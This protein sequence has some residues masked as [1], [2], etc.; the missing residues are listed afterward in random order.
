MSR[1][2]V[3]KKLVYMYRSYTDFALLIVL[4][5]PT[6][7]ER[8]N[9]ERVSKMFN[10]VI[11][12]NSPN[13][14]SENSMIGK[15]SYLA[16]G[17]NE[18]IAKAQNIGIE[19]L[20]RTSAFKYI[21][22]FDQDS[23]FPN[24]YPSSIVGEYKRINTMLGG[25]L[26]CL[27]AVIIDKE[28][29]E[30]YKS[31]FHKQ[32]LVREDFV[33]KSEVISSG[34]CVAMDMFWEVGLLDEALFIDFV[35]T[36]WCFRA[37]R[38]GYVCGQTTRLK[39]YHK[40]GLRKIHVGKHIILLSSPQRFYFQYRNFILLFFRKYVPVS[41]K[42]FKGGKFFLRWLYFPFIRGGLVRWNYMNKGICSGM[43]NIVKAKYKI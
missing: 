13:P 1:E 18:G 22:F 23:K 37:A 5:N 31:V 4:F 3:G 2:L 11:V 40:V 9:V 32:E 41:F 19:F 26:S 34:S 43:S 39:L 8:L 27:G 10:G 20:K 38:L 24:S 16:L 15:M 42:F 33:C 17:K 7:E 28:D 30:E 6:A 21:V 14:V 35:D 25:K 36:E 29:G 12:D